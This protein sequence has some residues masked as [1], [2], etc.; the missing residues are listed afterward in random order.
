MSAAKKRKATDDAVNLDLEAVIAGILDREH[1]EKMTSEID[2][3]L[4]ADAMSQLDTA[5]YLAADGAPDMLRRLIVEK[6]G[7]ERVGAFINY[8]EGEVGRSTRAALF[9]R[10]GETDPRVKP[11]LIQKAADIERRINQIFK[12]SYPLRWRRQH[13]VTWSSAKYAARYYARGDDGVLH[14]RLAQAI[15]RGIDNLKDR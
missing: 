8:P 15:E 2:H 10:I 9:K 5:L 14:P 4:S 1:S 11:T 6:F 12:E 7:D 13:G 3:W